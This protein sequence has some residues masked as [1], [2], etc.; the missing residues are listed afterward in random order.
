MSALLTPS[1]TR[2]MP[3]QALASIGGPPNSSILGQPELAVGL[4]STTPSPTWTNRTY[5][6]DCWAEWAS[7][8]SAQSLQDS[9]P[10]TSRSTIVDTIVSTLAKASTYYLTTSEP[11]TTSVSM[12]TYYQTGAEENHNAF[13][14]FTYMYTET[15]TLGGEDSIPVSTAPTVYSTITRVTTRQIESL[16]TPQPRTPT[17]TLSSIVPQCQSQWQQWIAA[18]APRTRRPACSQ[19][20]VDAEQCGTAVSAYYAGVPVHGDEGV[21][22]WVTNGTSTFWPTTMT[23]APQC[24]LGC[25]RCAI[26]GNNVKLLYWQPST[27]HVLNYS[28]S[29]GILPVGSTNATSASTVVF[30]GTTLTSPTVYISYDTLYASNSCHG[31]GGTFKNT[32]IPVRTED[33]SSLAYQPLANWA[34]GPGQWGNQQL[35]YKYIN[36]PFNFT[37]LA[38]PVPD[39]VY[40]QLP[41]CQRELRGWTN[42]G[43]NA[44]K[45]TCTPRDASYAPLIAVP[46]EV[47]NLDPAWA[48]CTA[49]YGGLFDPPEA[50]H[51]VPVAATPTTPAP[52][53]TPSASAG[54]A[55]T[56]DLPSPTTGNLRSTVEVQQST[57]GLQQSVAGAQQSTV[58]VSATPNAVDGVNTD[59]STSPTA[60]R[61]SS[62]LIDPASSSDEPTVNQATV[63][64]LEPANS[65][66]AAGQQSS[67]STTIADPAIPSPAGVASLVA[68]IMGASRLSASQSTSDPQNALSVLTAALTSISDVSELPTVVLP[69]SSWDTGFDALSSSPL[70]AGGFGLD[71]TASVS[72]PALMDPAQT[73]ATPQRETMTQSVQKFT[74]GQSKTVTGI[75]VLLPSQD[76]GVGPQTT[77]PALQLT[78]T[79]DPTSTT[80][81]TGEQ[82]DSG[83][84][85]A[86]APTLREQTTAESSDGLATDNLATTGQSRSSTLPAVASG[87]SY[88]PYMP[89]A[90]SSASSGEP[91]KITSLKSLRREVV[92]VAFL[93]MEKSGAASASLG[94]RPLR[95]FADFHVHEEPIN[96]FRNDRASPSLEN[97]FAQTIRITTCSARFT[98]A[99]L[100]VT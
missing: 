91:K 89:D 3:L 73:E 21:P 22:A 30:D 29:T 52:V 92:N 35:S 42:A 19:A 16:V 66:S 88:I 1:N 6:G 17:C 80:P 76:H 61:D 94:T 27:A 86:P 45:F 60:S 69:P 87:A 78:T 15:I 31:V 28:I 97:H 4:S 44:S 95:R 10:S 63:F 37:D 57:S 83:S 32:I 24:T 47:R 40:N 26:T 8:W 72:D 38:E 71:P 48:S 90:S 68:S 46:T 20:S 55:V 18:G 64:S 77:L 84:Q 39:S 85:R 9:N 67:R 2:P 75:G 99:T 96:N 79:N 7:Y 74:E 23:F 41:W 50:L 58:A 82:T 13:A 51:G 33:L 14:T 59:L 34:I 49:W 11:L 12:E 70:T 98:S 25:Q 5:I 81:I 43:F 93:M 53:K 36:R 62:L 100:A 65:M 54:S 56:D